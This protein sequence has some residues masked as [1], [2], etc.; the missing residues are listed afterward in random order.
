[1]TLMTLRPAVLIS[2]DQV[3]TYPFACSVTKRY[4]NGAHLNAPER[5]S[6]LVEF[7]GGYLLSYILRPYTDMGSI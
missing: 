1:M 2:N 4:I 7:S 3:D 5:M 6:I